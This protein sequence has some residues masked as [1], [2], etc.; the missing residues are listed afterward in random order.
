MPNAGVSVHILTPVTRPANLTELMT[1][2]AG[3]LVNAPAVRVTWHIALDL[4]REHV[5]DW[6]LRN[7]MLDQISDGWIWMLDD[8]TLAHPLVLRRLSEH[9]DVDGLAFSQDGRKDD[10]YAGTSDRDRLMSGDRREDLQPHHSVFDT[11]MAILRRSLFGDYRFKEVRAADGLLWEDVIKPA[12][13]IAYLDEVLGS[14]NALRPGEW[15]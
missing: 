11:G 1:S 6:A 2:V 5:G 12:E 8:D 4:H 15:G 13:N 3:A 7:A 9:Q 10:W 14:Y